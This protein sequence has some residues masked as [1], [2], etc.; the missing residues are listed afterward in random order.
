MARYHR[1]YPVD[2]INLS[3]PANQPLFPDSGDDTDPHNCQVY[4]CISV[5]TPHEGNHDERMPAPMR[6]A[7]HI[8]VWL[9][10]MRDTL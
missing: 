5:H 1:H 9:N 2:I 6:N 8:R 4:A 3:L 10:Q 7:I